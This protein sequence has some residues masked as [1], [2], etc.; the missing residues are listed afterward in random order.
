MDEALDTPGIE[1]GGNGS[2]KS[3]EAEGQGTGSLSAGRPS[4]VK[5]S[6]G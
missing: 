4:M 2:Q 5:S 1:A 3:L 6:R